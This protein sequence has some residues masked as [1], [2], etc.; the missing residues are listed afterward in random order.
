MGASSK[1]FM[2]CRMSL[3]IYQDIPPELREGIEI[4]VIDVVD[5][6]YT[7]DEL[8]KDLKKKSDK[9]FKELK[10]REFYL[11]HKNGNNE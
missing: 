5:F 7:K 10:K 1:E 11:R 4:R 8:H 9:A 3:Q 6:D 2:N